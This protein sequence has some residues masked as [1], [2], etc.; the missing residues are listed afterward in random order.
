MIYC[1]CSIQPRESTE[2]APTVSASKPLRRTFERPWNRSNLL[3]T[4]LGTAAFVLLC[5]ALLRH[6]RP[7]GG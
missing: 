6:R 4:V 2:P 7:T 5:V 3:R 1:S